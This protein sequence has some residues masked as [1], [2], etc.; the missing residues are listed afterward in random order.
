MS[1]YAVTQD[2][3][4]PG[5]IPPMSLRDAKLARL[6]A[7]LAML[8]PLLVSCGPGP[9][10]IA[11]TPATTIMEAGDSVVITVTAVNTR[12]VWP[13]DVPGTF[14]HGGRHALYTP[15]ASAGVYEFTVAASA[16]ATKTATVSIEVFV[17][18]T[19]EITSFSL[20]DLPVGVIDQ[21]AQTIVFS[22]QQWIDGLDA[23]RAEFTAVGTVTVNGVEQVNGVTL[24]DFRTDVL[25]TVATGKFARRTYAVRVESP[26][27]TGLPVIRIDTQENQEIT[28]KETYVQTNIEVTDPLHPDYSFAHADYADQIRGRGNSTW[29][30]PKKPYRIK[31]DKKTS[32]FGFPAAKSWVLLANYQDPTLML[33][34]VAF[35][36]G[37]RLGLPYANHHVPVELFL[38]AEYQGSYVLTE[39]IQVGEGRVD[40][41]EDDGLLVELDVYYDEDPKFTTD[42]YALPVMIKSPED[43]K[44]PAGYDFVK[45]A[46]NGLEAAMNSPSFPDSGYRDRIDMRTFVDFLLANEMAQNNEI[47]WPKSVYMY[48]DAAGKFGMGPLW[49]FDWGFGYT[50]SGFQYFAGADAMIGKH[51]FFNRFF[52]DPQFIALYK[53]RWN[54]MYEQIAD[55]PRF[56]AESANHL[57]KSQEQNFRRWPEARNNGFAQEVGDLQ[58]WWHRRVDFLNSAIAGM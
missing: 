48:R 23:L 36:L 27:A 58:D 54:D 5:R 57:R 39:Q 8:L 41:D 49:D 20:Q 29:G 53:A 15:P 19:P 26:Q 2:K 40:I 18:P 12:I 51:A 47:W 17:P 16:D 28:S 43:L 24:N 9:V 30:Y 52:E 56:I 46:V 21:E 35:E 25:Y 14:I 7:V 3:D 55:M 31:F 6:F 34:S 13:D 38:N 32:M 37:Q 11:L 42:I 10:S 44:D 1:R 33:N 50:G 22:T 45:D 4:D